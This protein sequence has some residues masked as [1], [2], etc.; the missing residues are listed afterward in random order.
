MPEPAAG[1]ADS[2]PKNRKMDRQEIVHQ[3]KPEASRFTVP[4]SPGCPAGLIQLPSC[5]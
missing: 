4:I 5:V 3:T 2:P 1:S